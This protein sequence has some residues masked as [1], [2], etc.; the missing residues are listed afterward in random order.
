MLDAATANPGLGGPVG[1]VASP[2]NKGLELRSQLSH[3]AAMTPDSRALALAARQG[4][5]INQSQALDCGL[6][7]SGIFRRVRRGDWQKVIRSVYRLV[8]MTDAS[9]L[10]RAAIAALPSAVV[11]HE[12][13]AERHAIPLVHRGK[14]V[15]SVHTRTTHSFP[16]VIIH[17]NHDLASEHVTRIGD[18]PV[19][20]VP[21]TIL[22]LAHILSGKHVRRI[23]DDLIADRRLIV[24][25]LTAIH[26]QVAKRGKPG[27]TALRSILAERGA[28]QGAK[29]SRLELEG[30]RVL[31]DAGLPEPILEY[32]I[33]WNSTKRF[34]AAYPDARLAIEWDSRRWHGLIDSFEADRN[35][36]RAALLH[37]WKVLRFTWRDVTDRP[38][39]V[40]ATVRT[41]ME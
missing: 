8:D 31:R 25:D 28:G 29:A 23:V 6:S 22:D 36:D 39:E 17:R 21:R 5:V 27:S 4:G 32:P 26:E 30:L 10:L 34:D 40:A 24:A 33:P 7:P 2:Q 9:D 14:A 13:A 11:S 35:R 15:V 19:T 38:S 16:G 20:T 37:K 41:L 12:S 18:L 1:A 3:H